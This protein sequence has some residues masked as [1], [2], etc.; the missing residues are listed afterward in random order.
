M[1]ERDEHPEKLNRSVRLRRQRRDRW[2]REGER[3]IGRNL[4][5]IGV[6]GWLIVTPTLV[7]IFAGRWLDRSYA[8]GIFWTTSLLFAGL[9]LGCYLAWKRVHQ[10]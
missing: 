7:G 3:S 2:L 5:M 1:P 10:E 9:V 6:L 4:A 8:T